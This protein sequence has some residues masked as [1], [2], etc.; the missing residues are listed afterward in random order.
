MT[1]KVVVTTVSASALAGVSRYASS[2][3]EMSFVL[4]PLYGATV[5]IR[6]AL[7]AMPS[8]DL[9]ITDLM[10]MPR[11]DVSRFSSALR[12]CKGQRL[13]FGGMA[14]NL[15]RLGGYDEEDFSSDAEDES[16][17]HT[18]SQCWKRAEGDDI[19]FIL[20]TALGRYLGAPGLPS[21]GMP[22]V[23]EGVFLKDPDTLVE[24]ASLSEYRA[25]HPEDGRPVVALV[26]SGN[27]YPGS[28]KAV[29]KAV[30]DGLK[31]FADVVPI[32]LSSY[33]IRDTVPMET[34]LAG[35][36]AVVDLTPFRFL[37]GPMGG[38]SVSAVDLLKRVGSP[39]FSPFVLSG[40]KE[41][42]MSDPE[43]IGP[44]EFMLDVF[45]PELDGAQLTIPVA[46]TERADSV[47]AG[48]PM[49]ES[50]PLEDRVSR[51]CGKV[52]SLIELRHKPRS[53]RKV[54]II[55][56]DYPPGE[57]GLFG[58]SFLDGLGSVGSILRRLK[59]E[60]YT[61][62]APSDEEIL[63][64]FVDG[65]LVNGDSWISNDRIIRYKSTAPHPAAVSAAWGKAPGTVMTDHDSYLIPGALFGNVFVG[66]QPSRTLG[67]VT[68]EVYHDKDSVPHHQYLAFYEWVRDSFK[69][70][71]VV[72][73]G[74]HGTLEFLPGKERAM[75]GDCYPDS[76][77]GDVPHFYLYYVGN[78]SEAMIAKRRS[79]AVLVSYMPPPFVES[80]TYGDMAEL[81]SM[82]T[83]WREAISTDSGRA[84]D[85][86]GRIRDRALEMRLPTDVDELEDELVSIRTSLIPHGLHRI[87][88]PYTEEESVE[89]AVQ[90]MAYPHDGTRRLSEVVP[91]MTEEEERSAYRERLNRAVG[92]SSD[93][94]VEASL[95]KAEAIRD[96]VLICREL[97]SLASV[98]DGRYVEVAPGGD[99]RVD[100]ECL[101]S[102]R[103]IVQFNPEKVP[104]AAAF[105]RGTSMAEDM[106]EQYRRE[107]G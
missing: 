55:G 7:E 16:V 50:S 27:S 91:G 106:L 35:S 24:F 53:E 60:G 84:E 74:T 72:H 105:E 34:A 52:R 36:E 90:S 6:A 40:T 26:F 48:V 93:Q 86:L 46:S 5:D 11:G 65:G 13:C 51:L 94:A 88:S 79:N 64:R 61:V 102:G 66:I 87:G 75:S 70:D 56:Y 82:I 80:G 54:A 59:E 18:M 19:P 28:T 78:P 63:S 95:R 49:T 17:F 39:I 58:G 4:C 97:D 57:G 69:A 8:A 47:I 37:A 89:F 100:E 92:G 31:S 68:S 32:A 23:R 67:V 103:N 12:K 62:E 1:T 73:L 29:S 25:T 76:V 83:E 98:L 44:M 33:S 14:P 107:H 10:G 21:H 15:S 3:P 30:F 77:M 85:L 42:W 45:L 81:E 2:H 104:T 101:P 9:A 41:D 43:G 99:V 71:A 38:D 22:S 96:S 20:D